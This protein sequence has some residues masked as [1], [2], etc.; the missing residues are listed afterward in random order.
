[1]IF[2][3]T[4]QDLCD[5]FSNIMYDEFEMSMMGEFNFFLGLQIKQLEDGIF[6]NQSKYIKEMLKKFGLEDAK[7]IKTPM[8]SETKLT[9]DEDEES[10]DNTKYHG[11]I[12]SLLYLIASQM[13]IMFSVCLCARF[14]KAPKTSH[15]KVVK[16]SLDIL[17]E[18]G[19]WYP[20]ATGV[21]KIVYAYS[22][23]AGDY[24]DSK[25]TS[26]VCAFMG[27][28][29]TSW[30]SKKQTALAISTTEAE[31]VFTKKSCQQALW[32]KQAL[33][34]YDI[35]LDDISVLSDNKGA[36]DLSKNH[37]LHSH[38]KH[39]ESVITSFVTMSKKGTSPLKSD[40]PAVIALVSDGAEADIPPKT[41]TEKI[42]MRN[43]LKAKSTMLLAI[44]DEHLLKFHG[45]KD[46]KTLWEAIK[47]RFRGNKESKKM[48]K[49]ILKQQY[50]NFVASRS[51]DNKDLEQI[52]TDD[53]EE[54][55]LKWQV[56][57]Y[58][59]HMRGHFARECRAP[60]SQ[61]NTNRDN[62]RRVVPVETHANTL[63]V[64]DGM[65]CDWI[66]QAEEGPID[67]ALMPFSSSGSS[68][69]DTKVNTCFKEC[70][71]SY[72]TLQKQYDQQR[73][74]L[75]KAN[76]E[77]IAYQLGLESLESRIVINQKNDAV[78]EEDIAFLKYD[79][80]VRDNSI[81]ELKNQLKIKLEKF[82]TS[83]WNLTNLINSQLSSKDKSGLGYDSQLNERDLNNKSDVFES[84]SD[85]SVNESEEDNNQANDRYKAG[86]G[87][88]AIPPPY[89][90]NFM[91]SRPDM[92]FVG[93]VDYVFKS[94]INETITSMHETE[95]STSKTSKESM[96]KPKTVRPSAPIIED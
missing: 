66:Y 51:E 25:S 12:S 56:E 80:K 10:V 79:V 28:C 47:T 18:H 24:V 33:V 39:I 85:S 46:A 42:T 77:I 15:L 57:C 29:L 2:R 52:D 89:T 38:T 96:E 20:K 68:S 55:D 41:T 8:S 19:L 37:V 13:D 53:L 16:G 1:M 70:L 32:M 36:I 34:D 27:C 45:I 44:R 86:E 75:N 22:D 93:L 50:E 3:S 84:A 94:A 59:C 43:E 48:Q 4:C 30:F 63:V 64:T 92:S 17:R 54:M 83:S 62:I 35:A 67:F 73:E 14:Q 31:Y 11:M 65:G 9:R 5:D 23:H 81:T 72:Q 95:T 7:P 61:R 49:T 90:G 76:L 21:E 78:F 40:A 26:G 60:R 71:K 88:H 82:E 58:N 69:S 74:I 6:F 91:A 87:Y